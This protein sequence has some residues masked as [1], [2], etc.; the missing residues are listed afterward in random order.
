MSKIVW[1]LPVDI[2]DL[3]R[4]WTHTFGIPGCHFTCWAIKSTGIESKFLS[5][6]SAWDILTTTSC[7]SMRGCAVFQFYFRI[8]LRD[9]HEQKFFYD[10]LT[11]PKSTE[12][13]WLEWNL[14]LH[15]WDTGPPLYLLSYWVCRDWRQVFTQLNCTKY[16]C[17]L[18]VDFL[19]FF[20]GSS[21]G[22]AWGMLIWP[23]MVESKST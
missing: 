10:N 6:L 23:C 22:A 3:S 19:E 13:C 11:L 2:I 21:W 17:L 5:N 12:K 18:L 15:L 7:L 1:H 4:I 20:L 9:I 8:I 14:N 16:F